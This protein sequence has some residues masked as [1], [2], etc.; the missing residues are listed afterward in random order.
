MNILYAY[1]VNFY[2][3]NQLTKSKQ[4]KSIIGFGCY[5]QFLFHLV[6]KILC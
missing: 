3:T 6:F 4:A 1:I 2:N 5:I